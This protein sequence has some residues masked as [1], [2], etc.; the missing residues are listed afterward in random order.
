MKPDFPKMTV[1]DGR[2]GAAGRGWPGHI[3]QGKASAFAIQATSSVLPQPQPWPGHTRLSPP[4]SPPSASP[5]IP[6]WSILEAEMSHSCAHSVISMNPVRELTRAPCNLKK[7]L[8]LVPPQ[9]SLPV[10]H[11][12]LSSSWVHVVI[13]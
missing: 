5:P 6:D 9:P 2:A 1:K 4:P 11:C 13:R 3:M 12:L 7:D 10:W 8:V